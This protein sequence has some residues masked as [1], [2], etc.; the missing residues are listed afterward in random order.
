MTTRYRLRETAPFTAEQ[1]KGYDPLPA[2]L[3]QCGEVRQYNHHVHIGERGECE[4][5]DANAVCV[6]KGDYIILNANG[7]PADVVPELVF[8]RLYEPVSKQNA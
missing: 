8:G 6:Y 2:S 7:E 1:Y 3:C 4:P 5:P